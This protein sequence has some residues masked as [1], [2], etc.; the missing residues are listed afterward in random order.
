M[1]YYTGEKEVPISPASATPVTSDNPG[2]SAVIRAGSGNT[3]VVYIGGKDVTPSNGLPLRADEWVNI[4]PLRES[5][6]YCIASVA[7]QKLRWLVEK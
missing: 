7:G 2:S 3:G 1:S 4:S 6:L 5:E